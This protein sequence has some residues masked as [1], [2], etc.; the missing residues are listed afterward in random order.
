MQKPILTFST[1]ANTRNV[2]AI[3]GKHWHLRSFEHLS[4]T[5]RELVMRS[6]SEVMRL[7]DRVAKLGRRGGAAARAAERAFHQHVSVAIGLILEAPA[8]V[9]RKL[10]A[11]QKALIC[12][13]FIELATVALAATKR[14]ES[15]QPAARTKKTR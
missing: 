4:F 6:L 15:A 13:T 1:A 5:D 2:V 3:D 8:R 7:G 12:T 11:D 14:Q 9:V 10:R